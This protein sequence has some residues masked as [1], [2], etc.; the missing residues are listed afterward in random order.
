MK[1]A[2]YQS[3]RD[4]Y[5]ILQVSSRQFEGI[6]HVVDM[7][8]DVLEIDRPVLVSIVHRFLILQQQEYKRFHFEFEGQMPQIRLGRK[9]DL[10]EYVQEELSEALQG[11]EKLDLIE[12]A[13]TSAYEWY[14]NHYLNNVPSM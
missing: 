12:T 5:S 7:V 11:T 2:K 8:N 10:M 1:N 9:F 6:N 14:V 3:L 13:I 4:D